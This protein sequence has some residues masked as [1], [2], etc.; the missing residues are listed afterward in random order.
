MKRNPTTQRKSLETLKANPAEEEAEVEAT[1]KTETH[2]RR[3]ITT[4][5]EEE[6]EAEEVITKRIIPTRTEMTTKHQV[7]VTINIPYLII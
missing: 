6:V 4:A 5:K 7:N 3:V 1:M 2:T